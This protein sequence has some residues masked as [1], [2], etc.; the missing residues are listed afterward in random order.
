MNTWGIV[1]AA[2]LG[3]RLGTPKAFLPLNGKPMLLY[4][5]EA[6]QKSSLIDGI[7]MVC[8]NED[9]KEAEDLARRASISK[10]AF[11]IAGGKERQ[12]SVAEGMKALPK[13]AE[14]V[15]I[16]DC[17]R[18]LVTPGLIDAVL[19]KAKEAGGAILAV[20]TKDTIKIAEHLKVRETLNRNHLWTAQ[21]PQA[22][23]V[24]LFKKAIQQA[25][26]DR[27][28]G[29]DCAS[30]VERIGAPVHLVEGSPENF[31]VTT[32]N[33][34]AAAEAILVNRSLHHV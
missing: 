33:D 31:K 15:A 12:D 18:P 32:Q 13:E 34:L 14:F 2:G 3:A 9:L 4:S 5:M 30:L 10:L 25:A 20:P 11:V 21:T 16:H 23:R 22:F 7:V 24:E 1:L 8:R 6:F 26:A 29:T 19:K 17:A 28:Y 27:F